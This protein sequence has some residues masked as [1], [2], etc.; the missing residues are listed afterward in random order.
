M[1]RFLFYETIFC[2]NLEKFFY[3][4]RKTVIGKFPALREF[5]L[6]KRYVGLL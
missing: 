4:A 3:L 2:S 1:R 5:V 6:L